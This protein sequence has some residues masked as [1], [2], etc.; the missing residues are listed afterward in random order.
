MYSWFRDAFERA[1]ATF[2]QAFIAAIGGDVINVWHLDW[3][4]ATGLGLGGAL[5]SFMKSVA[6]RKVGERGTASLVD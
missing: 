5:L 6:A 1:S 2:A 3:K 4:T